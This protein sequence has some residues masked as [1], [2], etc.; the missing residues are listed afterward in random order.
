LLLV[1]SRTSYITNKERIKMA[2]FMTNF[3]AADMLGGP[4][5]VATPAKKAVKPVAPKVEAPQVVEA[6]VVVEEAPIVEEVV[7]VEEVAPLED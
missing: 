2:E 1:T 5:K 3:T 4:K 7:A 6:P